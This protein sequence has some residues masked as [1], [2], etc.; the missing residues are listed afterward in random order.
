MEENVEENILEDYKKAS[1][2]IKDNLTDYFSPEF[3]N[4]IDKVIVFNPLDKINIK[5][6]VKFQLSN[7][8]ERLEKM[9]YILKFDNKVINFIAKTV[10]N[11][12]F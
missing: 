11:P 8:A 1:Q 5:K 9:N 4:R 10:Y 7:L 2:K 6:I 3:V 12:D